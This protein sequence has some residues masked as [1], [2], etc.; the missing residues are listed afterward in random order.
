M[1]TEDAFEALSGL[2]SLPFPRPV[3]SKKGEKWRLSLYCEADEEWHTTEHSVYDFD[4]HANWVESL[5]TY[6]SPLAEQMR[7]VAPYLKAAAGKVTGAIKVEALGLAT[8]KLPDIRADRRKL[9][10]NSA[11]RTHPSALRSK[12]GARCMS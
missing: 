12:S 1:I 6:W 7:K 9:A 8:E 4:L 3:R 10:A 11:R 5:R 2:I